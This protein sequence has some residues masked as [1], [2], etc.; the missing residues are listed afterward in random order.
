MK[1]LVVGSGGREHALAWAI[2]KDPRVEKLYLAPGNGGARELGAVAENVP[3]DATD[4]DALI[5]FAK[6]KRIELA[7]VGPEQ[8]LALGIVNRFQAEGLNIVGPTKEAARLETSK[9][10]AKAFMKRHNIPTAAFEIFKSPSEARAYVER[11]TSFPIVVKASGLAAGKGVVVATHKGDAL[12]AVRAIFEERIFGDAGDEIVIE[13]FLQGEEASVFVIADGEDYKLLPTAQDHKR[14]GEGDI[15][16]NTGGMGAY[17]PAPIVTPSAMRKVEERIIQP[18]LRAMREEGTPYR[19]FLYVGLMIQD[20]EPKVVEFNA[21][22]GDPE[23]Q[24]ILPLLESSFLELLLA[25]TEGR[26]RG[27]EIRVADKFAA[28]VVMASKGYPDRYDTGKVITGH[29]HFDLSC[30]A[31]VRDGVMIFHAGTKYENGKLL[32]NGGRVLAITAVAD[33]LEDS[34]KRCYDAIAHIHFDGAHYRRDIGWRA[35]RKR[36]VQR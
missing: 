34:L 23:A 36:H 6:E 1:I 12:E 15:G 33:A 31:G 21:R 2:L 7:V 27:V 13:E 8:P 9:A 35:L 5:A 25:A 30:D 10:F 26:L 28:T 29:C 16:K 4:I 32:T 18:T 14:V 24:V 20:D 3:I 17:A 22:L 19:G 11:Q